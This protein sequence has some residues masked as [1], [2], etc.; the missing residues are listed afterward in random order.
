M[1]RHLVPVE[2]RVETTADQGVQADRVAFDQHRLERLDAHT[3]QSRR[4]V[5]HHRVVT[6]DLFQ[7]VPDLALTAL[8]HALS[9]LDG[10]C[11]AQIFETPDNE[12]LEEFQGDFLGQTTLGESQLRANHDHRTGAVIHTLAQQVFAETP[13]FALDHVGQRLERTVRGAE[14]GTT[15]ASVVEQRIDSLLQHALLVAYDDFR[16]VQINQLLEAVVAVD[17]P[18]IQ[19][20]QIA[21]GEVA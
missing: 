5:E 17:Q 16:G 14:H 9:G 2:V 8:K 11:K 3:V 1:H 21:G 10:V 19:I 18:A 4:A 12:G 15:T 13:L 6:G 20:V 7:N